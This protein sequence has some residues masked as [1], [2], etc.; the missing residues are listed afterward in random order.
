[1]LEHFVKTE[2]PT[3]FKSVGRCGDTHTPCQRCGAKDHEFKAS[4]GYRTNTQWA[5]LAYTGLRY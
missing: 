1:M 3:T 2:E 4:L 5:R